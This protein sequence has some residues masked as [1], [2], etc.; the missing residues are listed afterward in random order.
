M[1]E[2]SGEVWF[3]HLERASLEQVLPELLEK[4]LARGWRALVRTGDAEQRARLDAWLWTFRDESFLPHGIA[5]EATAD[6]QP[7]L[8][9]GGEENV[10]GAQA[11]FVLDEAPADIGKPTKPRSWTSPT[12]SR[13][14]RGGGSGWAKD[15]RVTASVAKP[16]AAHPSPR[17]LAFGLAAPA[18]GRRP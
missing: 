12:G 3:Y 1:S 15:Q 6:R 16:D 11:L 7:I 8:L 9:T 18:R 14:K 17:P 2:T 10:N 5:G 4:T 13:A